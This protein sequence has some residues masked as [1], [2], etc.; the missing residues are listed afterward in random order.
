MGFLSGILKVGSSF[1]PGPWSA[2][3]NALGGFLGQQDTNAQNRQMALDQMRFQQDMSG[4]AHQREVKDLAAAGLNPMLSS[5]YGG[6]STPAGASAVVGNSAAAADEAATSAENRRL[7]DAQIKSAESQAA[8]N[9]A[10]AAK[11]VVEA[12]EVASR[13]DLSELDYNTRSPAL[14]HARRAYNEKLIADIMG[15]RLSATESANAH[16][17][18]R[19]LDDYYMEKYGHTLQYYLM[20][21]DADQRAEELRSIRQHIRRSSLDF[22]KAEAEAGFYRTDFGKEIAPYISSA[23]GLSN[24]AA[25]AV[26]IGRKFGVGLRR[27]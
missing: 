19:N 25:G 11:A 22:P 21:L 8:L 6:A 3:A 12:R 27:K 17:A 20:S 13:A 1:L 23:Q 26:G 9:S 2:A 24:V 18:I 5:R 15:S 16:D 7:I 4:T 14:D 10:N